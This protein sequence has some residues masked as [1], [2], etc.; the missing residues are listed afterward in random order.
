M[1]AHCEMVDGKHVRLLSH[2]PMVYHTTNLP[3][4]ERTSNKDEELCA[5]IYCL[6]SIVNVA[7]EGEGSIVICTKILL[8]FD[9]EL[10]H[11]AS[12]EHR[13]KK[14]TIK[15][16]VGCERLHSRRPHRQ[17]PL[18]V[19]SLTSPYNVHCTLR[20]VIRICQCQYGGFKFIEQIINID[21]IKKG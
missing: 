15:F 4:T 11:L 5:H 6:T 18:E 20:V 16:C 2:M 21:D 14:V 19:F 9:C 17:I 1:T 8:G 3:F 7:N 12:Q 10:S 13:L